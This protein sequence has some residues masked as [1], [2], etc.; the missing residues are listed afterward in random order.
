MSLPRRDCVAI[1]KNVIPVNRS[2]EHSE[3]ECEESLR[4]LPEFTLSKHEG[5]GTRISP[6][7]RNEKKENYDTPASRE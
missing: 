2:P 3:G 7:S 5:L 1:R 6:F 4:S